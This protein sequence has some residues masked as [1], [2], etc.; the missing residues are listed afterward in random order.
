[1]AVDR[2]IGNLPQYPG[3]YIC[4]KPDVWSLE[5]CP[6]PAARSVFLRVTSSLVLV[7]PPSLLS[8]A[9]PP[10]SGKC[11]MM[12]PMPTVPFWSSPTLS[13]RDEH[14]LTGVWMAWM[15]WQVRSLAGSCVVMGSRG[16]F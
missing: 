1:M 5:A 6:R 10:C 13:V 16:G 3:V 11:T 9:G 15:G 2:D 8:V 4:S 12:I 14:A 7:L